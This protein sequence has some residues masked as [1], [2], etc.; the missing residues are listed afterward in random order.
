MLVWCWLA[1]AGALGAVARQVLATLI[2]AAAGGAM[3]VGVLVV[4]VLGCTLFGF[5]VRLGGV[6]GWIG[7]QTQAVLLVGFLGAFTTFS[8][9]VADLVEMARAGRYGLVALHVAGH[10]VLGVLGLLLG[11]WFAGVVGPRA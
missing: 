9:Y 10:N 11:A 7:P 8:T 4:N 2:P 5:V 3:Q 6:G 1:L